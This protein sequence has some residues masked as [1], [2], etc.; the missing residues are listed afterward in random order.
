MCNC[1]LCIKLYQICIIPTVEELCDSAD[2]ELF[3]K[4]VRL[5]NHI[6]HDLL[7]PPSNASQHYI[8]TSTSVA[9]CLSSL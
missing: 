1:A 8:I 7:P 2:D 3:G 4:T 6:L 9:D 5:M